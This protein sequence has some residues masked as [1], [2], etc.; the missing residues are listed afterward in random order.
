MFL[1]D[2]DGGADLAGRAVAALVAVEVEERLLDRVQFVALGHAFD[3]GDLAPLGG[4]REGEAG[5]GAPLVH[6]DGA[7]SALPL[8]AALLVPV[9]SRRSRR[10]SS[11]VVRWST[12]RWCFSPL[13]F[14]V[15]ALDVDEVAGAMF[16][17]LWCRVTRNRGVGR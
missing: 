9:R 6:Q 4:D 13:M 2:G 1:D 17:L 10:A 8:V 16:S 7:G 12:G 5:D 14:R 11:R 15:M 3:G